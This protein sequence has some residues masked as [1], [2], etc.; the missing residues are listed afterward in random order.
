LFSFS[1]FSSST[2]FSTT[3]LMRPP[4]RLSLAAL[5]AGGGKA[6]SQARKAEIEPKVHPRQGHRSSGLLPAHSEHPAHCLIVCSG[7]WHEVVAVGL[8]WDENKR[9]TMF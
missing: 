4:S 5:E 1:V 8:N 2:A 9:Q 7:R 6:P 3:L